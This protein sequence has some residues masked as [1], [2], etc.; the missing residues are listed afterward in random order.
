[1]APTLHSDSPQGLGTRIRQAREAAGLIQDQL[2][3]AVGVGSTAVTRWET[4]KRTPPAY[5]LSRVARTLN[6]SV[7][8]LL[9]QEDA[10]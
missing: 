4:G 3:E 6:V 9:G 10:A 5:R 2:A 1:M 7:D 8:Y